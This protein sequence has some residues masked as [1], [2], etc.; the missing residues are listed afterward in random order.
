MSEPQTPPPAPPPQPAKKGLSP[1]AWILIGCLGLLMLLALGFGACTFFVAKKAKNF[2]EDFADNPGRAAAELAVRMNPDLEM[3][4]TD[5]DDQTITVRDKTTGEE[6]TFDWSDF[7]NEGFSIST[8][9]G[10]MTINNPADG[11]AVVTMR[12][13]EGQQTTYF[14]DGGGSDTPSWVP[15]PAGASEPS[16]LMQTS[17]G[18]QTAGAFSYT[19]S[20]SVGSLIDYYE[21]ELDPQG[22]DTDRATYS[23]GGQ[24]GGSVTA[25]HADGRQLTI[26]LS[27]SGGETNVQVNHS[28]GN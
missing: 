10:S 7:E 9:E 28:S 12:D 27:S 15:I 22:F 2:A 25:T 23:G 24:E 1:V 13:D 4:S 6:M 8:G 17:G 21:G 19:T 26:V 5:N 16:V 18:S 14:G 11:G 3:V 20:Q